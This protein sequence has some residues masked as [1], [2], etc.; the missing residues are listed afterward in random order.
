[1]YC[2]TQLLLDP[3]KPNLDGMELGINVR[4]RSPVVW[5]SVLEWQGGW[6][7]LLATS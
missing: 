4:W 3:I 1:M 5:G 2:N 6:L 7:P